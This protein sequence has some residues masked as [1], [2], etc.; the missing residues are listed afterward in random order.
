M[1][2][3]QKYA[4]TPASESLSMAFNTANTAPIRILSCAADN[5]WWS[6]DV[7]NE[8]FSAEEWSWD[9]RSV[10]SSRSLSNRWHVNLAPDS[11]S[12]FST[13]NDIII[14]NYTTSRSFL[15]LL[16]RRQRGIGKVQRFVTGVQRVVTHQMVVRLEVTAGPRDRSHLPMRNNFWL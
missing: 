6:R 2:E 4:H 15:S 12:W 16:R 10:D 14:N 9:M 7:L 13:P 1:Y 8:N 11:A 3:G 5:K